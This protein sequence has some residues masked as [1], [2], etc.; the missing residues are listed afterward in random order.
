MYSARLLGAQWGRIR[1]GV[2]SLPMELVHVGQ[3]ISLSSIELQA[4]PFA[5]ADKVVYPRRNLLRTTA[6][7]RLPYL[8]QRPVGKEQPVPASSVIH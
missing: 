2:A 7:E 1:L 6:N 8:F 5:E 4:G 3:R